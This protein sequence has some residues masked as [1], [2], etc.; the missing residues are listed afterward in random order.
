MKIFSYLLPT[1]VFAVLF[2][3]CCGVTPEPARDLTGTWSGPSSFQENVEGAQCTIRGTFTF[4]FQQTDNAVVG[5]YVFNIASISQKRLPSN[6]DVPP[7]GCSGP[8]DNQLS[9]QVTGTVSSSAVTLDNIEG[10]RQFLGSYIT[11][12]M[13]LKLT[14]CLVNDEPCTLSNSN[15]WNI[16][17]TRRS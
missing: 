3:G 17:L 9:G 11:D 12:S 8:V 7:V 13:G 10:Q 1:L 5:D 14:R 15:M 6:S 4:H 16:T 2:L